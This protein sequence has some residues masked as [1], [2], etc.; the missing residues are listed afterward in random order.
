MY[1]DKRL[2]GITAVQTLSRLNRSYDGK[3]PTYI[4]DFVNDP[5]EIL[6]AFRTYYETVALSNASCIITAGESLSTRTCR[7]ALG[8]NRMSNIVRRPWR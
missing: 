1:V 8:T 6:T 2:A 3:D 7:G 5:E 4:V